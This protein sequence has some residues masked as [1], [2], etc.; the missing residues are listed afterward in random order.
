MANKRKRRRRKAS[1]YIPII[2]L[3][4]VVAIV[5]GL[6]AFFKVSKI[7]VEGAISY[8][9][10]EIIETSGIEI[11][12]NLFLI[13]DSAVALRLN[14]AFVYIDEIKITHKLPGTVTIKLTECHPIACVKYAGSYWLIDKN[15]KLLEK[16]SSAGTD[17][18]IEIIGLD[19]ILPTAGEK[20]A[21][22]EDNSTQLKYLTA[23]LTAISDLGMQNDITSIDISSTSNITFDY[24]GRFNVKLGRGDNARDKLDLLIRSVAE[25]AEN[26]TGSFDLS[27]DKEAIFKSS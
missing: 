25:E 24:L 5:I 17:G 23:I 22:G 4:L 11:G 18:A 6:S 1:L 27:V 16:V 19:P 8:S 20:I 12:D 21:L 13:K 2:I 7:E 10:D 15:A 9:A 14:K 26:A 3:V